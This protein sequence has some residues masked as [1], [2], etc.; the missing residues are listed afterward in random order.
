[1]LYLSHMHTLPPAEVL[2]SEHVALHAADYVRGR[3]ATELVEWVQT[4]G[5]RRAA[6]LASLTRLQQ[7]ASFTNGRAPEHHRLIEGLIA[8]R[9]VM[10][11]EGSNPPKATPRQRDWLRERYEELTTVE[12]EWCRQQVGTQTVQLP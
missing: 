9:A 8:L 2:Q 1:M 3:Q 10:Y 11:V 12:C 6:E 7:A 4:H 5:Y